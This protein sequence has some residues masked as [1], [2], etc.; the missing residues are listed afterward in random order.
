[1]SILP[2]SNSAGLA[3]SFT[4]SPLFISPLTSDDSTTASINMSYDGVLHVPSPLS[5]GLWTQTP[6]SLRGGFRFLTIISTT[7]DAVSISNITCSISF[8]PHVEDLRAYTG[9]FYAIDPVFHDKN[10]LTKV[11]TTTPDRGERSYNFIF[12]AAL[13]RRCLHSPD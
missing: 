2:S 9:Y 4:E 8:M 13:V 10:F 1:M 5:P 6:A 12:G 7:Q 3:L 11:S